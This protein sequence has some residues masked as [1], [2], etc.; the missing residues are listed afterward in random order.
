MQNNNNY[1]ESLDVRLII[2]AIIKHWK[3]MLVI[4]L[5]FAIAFPIFKYKMDPP[6]TN[7]ED[8]S[9]NQKA[10]QADS[11]EVA[12]YKK[13]LD[14]LSANKAALEK[15]ISEVEEESSQLA[16]EKENLDQRK[17][18]SVL[19]SINPYKVSKAERTYMIDKMAGDDD[20]EKGVLEKIV[21]AYAKS[22]EL[23]NE[24]M[25]ETLTIGSTTATLCDI[26]TGGNT[27]TISVIA[28]DEK[29]A[30]TCMENADKAIEKAKN[31]VEEAYGRHAVVEAFDKS[32]IGTDENLR[33]LQE[34]YDD[35]KIAAIISAN[36]KLQALRSSLYTINTQIRTTDTALRNALNAPAEDAD[37]ESDADEDEEE[38]RG[39]TGKDIVI[40]T[41][42][43]FVIGI[44]LTS[45]WHGFR[46]FLS[47]T[48]RCS[49]DMF[50]KFGIRLLGVIKDEESIPVTC[51]VIEKLIKDESG[52]VLVSTLGMDICRSFGQTIRKYNSQLE[53]E[54]AGDLKKEAKGLKDL[55]DDKKVVLLE[56]VDL[57]SVSAISYE[58]E[59]IRISGAEIIG[60]VID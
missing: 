8:S 25:N 4:S 39:T 20:I 32:F 36:D 5:V 33:L 57:S 26:T 29:T 46:Y 45:V 41:I 60:C 19:L 10:P 54:E 52:L 27:L 24:E 28:P 21:A 47:D 59:L 31:T 23:A 50:L 12:Q 58:I 13:E 48:L 22:A 38:K 43:G 30:E 51:E 11:P 1:S 14:V 6:V 7:V 34:G 18:E 53:I 16:K 49:D 44:I 3:S 17:S 55:A 56:K 2:R 42:L 15:Y 9:S 40:W 35:A 37:K